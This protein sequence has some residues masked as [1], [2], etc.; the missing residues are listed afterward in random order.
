MVDDG[1]GKMGGKKRPRVWRGLSL[2]TAN[3]YT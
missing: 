3:E 1:W 2:H